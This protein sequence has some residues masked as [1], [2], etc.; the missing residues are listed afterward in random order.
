MNNQKKDRRFG[1]HFVD[2]G[3]CFLGVE[4]KKKKRI[5]NLEWIISGGGVELWGNLVSSSPKEDKEL[6]NKVKQAVGKLS[7]VERGFIEKF[8]FEFKTYSQVAKELNKKIYKLDRIHRQALGKLRIILKDYVQS[9]FKI[10]CNQIGRCVICNHPQREKIDE[11]IKSKS[12]DETWKK[13]AKILE[14]KFGL[15]IKT[16]QVLMSHKNKHMVN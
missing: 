4:G 14:E 15:K 8:Y 12:K 13:V 10:K 9:R 5:R 6:K 16:P 7:L 2:Y 11:I 1:V 3:A